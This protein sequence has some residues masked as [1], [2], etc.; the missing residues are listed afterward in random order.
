MRRIAFVLVVFLGTGGCIHGQPA[1]H[2]GYVPIT[3]SKLTDK[4]HIITVTGGREFNMPLYRTNLLASVGP[5]GILLVD[6]G[7]EATGPALRDTLKFLGNGQLKMVISTHYHGDHTSGNRFLSDQAPVLAQQNVLTCMSGNYFHLLGS[8]SPNRPTVG[9]DDS[10]IIH[11]NGEEIHV[12][13]APKCHSDGDAY[14][15]FTASKVVAAG[16]LFFP[17]EI[18]YVDLPRNGTV[19]GY[20]AQIKRFMEIFPDDVTFVAAHGRSYNKKDLEQYHRM[21]TETVRLVQ[22]AAAEG[23]TAEQMIE[24]NLLADWA[25]WEGQFSNTTLAA[26]IQTVYA[27]LSG[28]TDTRPSICE[29]MTHTLIEGTVQDAMEEYRRLRATQPDAYDFGEN[30]LNMLGYQLLGRRRLGDALEIFKLNV[31]LYPAS[32]NVYD[33]YGEALLAAGDTTRSI[34]NYGRSLELNPENTNAVEVLKRL[35]PSD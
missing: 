9:F 3:I 2:S 22:Q 10:L 1:T 32:F 13:H 7:F 17:D 30:Q 31:E 33:S 4:L 11:F 28:I 14:L 8:P 21:L 20:A 6:A 34:V 5:D 18:P 19:S 27:E 23:R 29:P 24:Q 16:D 15:Y 25:D 26:W 12:V 35:R